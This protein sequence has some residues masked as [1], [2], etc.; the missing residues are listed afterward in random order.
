[1]KLGNATSGGGGLV[2]R[3]RLTDLRKAG[4]EE[5]GDDEAKERGRMNENDDDDYQDDG[6]V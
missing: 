4:R 2:D 6:R 5:G 3:I 1:M